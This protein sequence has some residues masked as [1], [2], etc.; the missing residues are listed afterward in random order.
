[1]SPSPVTRRF[2]AS[3][4][5]LTLPLGLMWGLPAAAQALTTQ[6]DIVNGEPGVAGEFPYLASVRGYVGSSYYSCGGAFVSSTKVVTAAHCFYDE[7]GNFISDVRVGAAA[8]TSL[9]SS[10]VSALRVE[11]HRDYDAQTQ[12]ND[13]AVITLER[14]VAGVTPV[15]IP[16]LAQWQG[17][18]QGGDAVQSAG[19]GATSSG[20]PSPSQFRVAD[21]TVIPDSAC[22][23]YSGTYR[24]GSVTYRGLGNT[25]NDAKMMC[26]GGATSTGLP[27]DTCQGDSGGPLVAGST[28]VGI[29]SWGIGCA[30]YDDGTPIRLTPGVYTR[31]GSYLDWLAARGVGPSTPAS[32]PGAPTGVAATVIDVGTFNVSWTA[33][34]SDGG[35]AITGYDI[36]ESADNGEWVALGRTETGAT[37]ID[38]IDVEPGVSY[39]Y[40]VAAVNSAGR[41]TFSQPS[42]PV[43]M[44]SDTVTAP[45][46]V[47]GFSKGKFT[48]KGKTYRVTVR[49]KPPVDD[50]GAEILGYIARV[51]YAGN[52][53]DWS[54]LDSPATVTTG[55]YANR[56]YTLQVQA[57]NEK[58][59]GPIASYSF[60]TPRR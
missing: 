56:K 46:A 37:N 20:G 26:A 50:G 3:I 4:A 29:V 32:I 11:V 47:S 45:G 24:V 28:L 2:A 33:P 13:I 44:P 27:I 53:G 19:W 34:A 7:D 58:G 31:L 15:T 12:D 9:P 1:M 59:P 21:L 60:T 41:G 14:A 6:P 42:A 40:R 55:L 51:G 18:T 52:W 10:R 8:G 48:K 49:W 38:I 39:R 23:D 54:D 5:A 22:G 35:A 57:L 30:G 43:V 17:L 25:F 36:E 16:N